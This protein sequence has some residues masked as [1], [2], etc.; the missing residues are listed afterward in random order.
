M[1]GNKTAKKSH[2]WERDKYDHY[3]E[4]VDLGA[5]I[6]AAL[7]LPVGSRVVDPCCGWG[8]MVRSARAADLQAF[9]SDIVARW[10]DGPDG[11]L[12]NGV[13][14]AVA[15]W[16][17]PEWGRS[18]PEHFARP[19][20]I[21]SNPPFDRLEEWLPLALD[22]A[23]WIVAAIVPHNFIWGYGRSSELEKTQF[24]KF[25]PIVPRASMPPGSAIIAGQKATGG[26]KDYALAVWLKNYR[27]AP[28][29]E[30]LRRA[31][32]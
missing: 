31:K 1:S 23:S 16:F 28:Q 4:P 7:D 24:W 11:P 10:P 12:P 2:V 9:G 26:T 6:F 21:V 18:V 25:M 17:S 8:R 30:W 3:V 13:S 5:S 27:G 19:A 14:F 20:A 29:I 32:R 22:R 15:D